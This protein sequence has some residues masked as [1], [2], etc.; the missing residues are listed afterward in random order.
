MGVNCVVVELISH[1]GDGIRMTAS[2]L[3]QV[4]AAA[5]GEGVKVKQGRFL[6]SGAG[7]TQLFLLLAFYVAVFLLLFLEF[8]AGLLLPEII[9]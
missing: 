7:W 1:R 3:Q 6:F 9:L 5:V 2:E 8:V 4:I